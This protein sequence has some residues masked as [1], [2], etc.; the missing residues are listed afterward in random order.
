M[1]TKPVPKRSIVAGSGTGAAGVRYKSLVGC[2]LEPDGNNFPRFS[3]F[4]IG[5][6]VGPR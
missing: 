2:V 5:G 1:P 3:H 6:M 4:M